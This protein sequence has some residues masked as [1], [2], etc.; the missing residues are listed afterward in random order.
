MTT[1]LRRT[2]A[3]AI[4]ALQAAD[5]ELAAMRVSRAQKGGYARSDA[6][7]PDRRREIAKK[8]AAARWG[9]KQ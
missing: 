2:I 8:A 7:T 6:L 5:A 4:K 3:T 9:K 1:K